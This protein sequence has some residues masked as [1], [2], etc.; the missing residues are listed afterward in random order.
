MFDPLGNSPVLDEFLKDYLVECQ[1]GLA[2]FEGDLVSLEREPESSAIAG[3]DL[4]GP[5]FDQGGVGFPRIRE[6]GGGHA[7]GGGAPGQAP[8]GHDPDVARRSSA[9]CW[10]WSTRCGRSSV[11]IESSACGGRARRLGPDRPASRPLAGHPRRPA[12]RA[13]RRGRGVRPTPRRRPG[14]RPGPRSRDGT[15]ARPKRPPP[16]SAV[17]PPPIRVN[18]GTGP[19]LGESTIR[20]DVGLLDKLMNLVG[21]LVLT[22]NQF[23][24]GSLARDEAA[25]QASTQR[26]DLI[27]TELQEGM[28]KTR[29]QPIRTISASLPRVVRDLALAC[30]KRRVDRH[31]GR[32]DRAGQDARRGDQG[33]DHAHHPQRRRPRD[34]AARRSARPGAS[35]PRAGSRSAPSTRGGWSTSSSPTTATGSTPSG[36]AARPSSAAGSRTTRRRSGPSA[37]WSA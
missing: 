30:G 9:A 29:M 37:S 3:V 31:G 2:Q 20:V 35:R 17:G 6:D 26:L 34:R 24:R 36:S 21:E 14:R 33:P 1:E 16:R 12:A 32:G 8:R 7:P 13:T 19:P 5:S 11:S 4:P 10:R 22:R 27:T 25:F 18:G 15:V 23:L 28:M